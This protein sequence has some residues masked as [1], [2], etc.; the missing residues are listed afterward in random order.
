MLAYN[1]LSTTTAMIRPRHRYRPWTLPA[2]SKQHVSPDPLSPNELLFE[3]ILVVA[4]FVAL[5]LGLALVTTGFPGAD[6]AQAL[7]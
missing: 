2:R 6:L 5:V 7:R 4:L 1:A 3:V